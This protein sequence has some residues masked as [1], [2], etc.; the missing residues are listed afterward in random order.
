VFGRDV[1]D[2]LGCGIRGVPLADGDSLES[3]WIVLALGANISAALVSR[4]ITDPGPARNCTDR[5]FDVAL[6]ND[7]A[8]VTKVARQLLTRMLTPPEP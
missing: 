5:R 8:L 6:T 2:N 3:Q 4:E 7:R 1:A